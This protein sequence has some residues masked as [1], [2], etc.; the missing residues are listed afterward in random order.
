MNI[1]TKYIIGAIALICSCK[2]DAYE[3]GDGDLSYMHAD[4]ADITITSHAVSSITTDSDVDLIPPHDIAVSSE[5]PADTMVRRLVYYNMTGTDKPI[6]ILRLTPVSILSPHSPDDEG[7]LRT[8]PVKLVSAWLSQNKR[9]INMQLGIMTGN[10]TEPTR[11][12]SLRLVCDSAHAIGKGAAYLS[13]RYDN[14]GTPE[15]YTQDLHISIPTDIL[16]TT[17][18]NHADTLSL[19][20]NT[21]SGKTTKVFIMSK[22]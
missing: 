14:A 12:R 17:E 16:K 18:G 9:Y 3:T 10:A 8:D 4:Y 20:V 19:T 21:Y 11:E 5:L 1:K 22:F 7:T 13:L 2:H 15:Y 6:E